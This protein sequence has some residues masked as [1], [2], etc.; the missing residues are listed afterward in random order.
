MCSFRLDRQ[1]KATS[2]VE[3]TGKFNGAVGSYNA[4]AVA[5]PDVCSRVIIF[6][7][8][9]DGMYSLISCLELC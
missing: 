9:L 7:L 8:L 1:V 4:H 3:I 6:L 2:A 5:Y